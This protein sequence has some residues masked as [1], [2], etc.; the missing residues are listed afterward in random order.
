MLI[1]RRAWHPEVSRATLAQDFAL[2]AVSLNVLTSNQNAQAVRD[3]LVG[4]DADVIFL[5]EVD[6]SWATALEPLHAK[7]P[8]RIVQPRNDNFGVAL[9]SRVPWRRGEV[10]HIGPAGLPSVEIGMTWRGRD[11][12]L[13]G[14]HTLPPMGAAWAALRDR[15]LAALAEHA[16]QVREPVLVVGD[17]NATPWSTGMRMVTAAS[18]GYRSRMAPWIPTWRARS[19]FAIPI[20]QALCSEPLV[21]AGRAVGPDVGSDHR[22]LLLTVGWAQ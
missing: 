3:Y 20:D 12:T 4:S 18:L 21:I 6:Q 9:L 5:M 13:I 2:R 16:G 15:H 10:V 14:T 7:Y 8:Y 1:G 11:F 19:I 22:P 17:L